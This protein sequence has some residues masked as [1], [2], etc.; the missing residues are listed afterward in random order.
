[1]SDPKLTFA[2]NLRTRLTDAERTLWL[3]LR[4]HRLRGYKFK[5]QQPLGPYI[6]DFVCFS[7]RLVIEVDGAQHL[8]SVRDAERDRWM[9]DNG[10]RILRFW[11]DQVLRETEAVLEA[12]WNA[13]GDTPSPQPASP[14]SLRSPREGRGASPKNEDFK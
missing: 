8:D 1:M 14:P 12:I 4:S 3:H 13:L 9:S 2:K 11:N 5:R 7:A 6:A 10:F